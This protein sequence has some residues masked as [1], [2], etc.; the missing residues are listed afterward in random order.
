MFGCGSITTRGCCLGNQPVRCDSFPDGHVVVLADCTG[1]NYGNYCGWIA[2]SAHAGGYSCID[3]PSSDPT[4]ESPRD[5]D[6][7]CTPDCAGK[8]CGPDECGYECG[9][10]PDGQVCNNWS[11]CTPKCG[12]RTC[13]S[14][15]CGGWCGECAPGSYCDASYHCQAGYGCIAS[16]GVAGCKGCA[17][18]ECVCAQDPLCCTAVWDEKCAWECQ[19]QCGGCLPCTPDCDGK[20]CGKDGCGGVCGDC[21][22]GA[23]C[24]G[25]ACVPTGPG[26]DVSEPAGDLAGAPDVAD[27]DEVG[28]ADGGTVEGAVTSDLETPD[29][30]EAIPDSP[31]LDSQ[32]FDP[33]QMGADLPVATSE[34]VPDAPAPPGDEGSGGQ[35]GVPVVELAVASGGGSTGCA[36]GQ[37]APNPAVTWLP[38]LIPAVIWCRRRTTRHV[39]S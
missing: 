32:P 24:H 6:F 21:G 23:E 31:T 16:H 15:G 17:C 33:G 25:V 10:C 9:Q 27:P 2:L 38:I 28:H 12:D 13:G 19:E 7:T 5:C 29:D 39:A 14:N 4:G 20:E 22:P 30:G 3:E 37:G 34:L 18:A 36:S 1:S 8:A 35:D 26:P 11:C